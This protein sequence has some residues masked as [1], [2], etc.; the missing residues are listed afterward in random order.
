[1]HV[2]VPHPWQVPIEQAQAIQRELASQVVRHQTFD[3]LHSVAGVD[4]SFPDKET[5]RAAVVVLSYPALEPLTSSVVE[6]P[7]TFPYVPGLLAFRE[8][9][10]ALDAFAKLAVEPDLIIVDGQGYAHPRRM[11]IACHLGLYLDTP[12]IGCAKSKLVGQY[13]MPAEE[14][15]AWSELRDRGEVI[16]AV[17]RTRDKVSPVF[18]SIGHRID[19]PTAIQAVLNCVRGYRLP[20][21]TR[22]AHNVAGGASLPNEGTQSRLF[23]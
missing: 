21:P 4:I 1:M 8:A 3:E 6:K 12:T 22:W 18:V 10:A 11:G 23:N 15:G 2:N 17:V 14:A 19:L 16:G 9:P 5:T 7:T 13:Q 20:E